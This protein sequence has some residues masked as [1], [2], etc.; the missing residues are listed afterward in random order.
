[1][2]GTG[3]LVSSTTN[4]FVPG[5][6]ANF[7][8]PA[9]AVVV[10]TAN[11]GLQTQSAVPGTAG[12]AMVELGLYA[13]SQT[14]QAGSRRR[15]TSTAEDGIQYWSIS[16]VISFTAGAHSVALAAFE[17]M[18]ATFTSHANVSG[19]ASVNPLLQGSITVTIITK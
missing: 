6:T 7:T 12:A 16:Q 11:G 5:L 13:D 10:V 3:T 19:N 15:I 14:L 4:F 2:L 18:P 1:M 8:V 9:N 17:P